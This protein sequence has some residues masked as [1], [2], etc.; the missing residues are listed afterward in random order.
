[1]CGVN[2]CNLAQN[3]A[4]AVAVGDLFGRDETRVGIREIHTKIGGT[5]FTIELPPDAKQ[6]I[7]V[8]DSLKPTPE[9]RLSLKEFS[10]DV[11]VP[12]ELIEAIG[13][14]QVLEILSKSPSLDLV[15]QD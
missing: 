7:R 8:F 3:C 9:I 13:I 11:E 2:D 15:T 12:E 10:F 14:N 5:D 6:F 4:I 1:M